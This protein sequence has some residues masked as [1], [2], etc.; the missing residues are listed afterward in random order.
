MHKWIVEQWRDG[1]CIRSMELTD[2]MVKQQS[3]G[4]YDVTFPQCELGGGLLIS[5]DDELRLS[6]IH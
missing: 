6:E 3:D 5:T 4:S 1:E 2:E